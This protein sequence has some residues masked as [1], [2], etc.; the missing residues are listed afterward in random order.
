MCL[1]YENKSKSKTVDE[2]QLVGSSFISISYYLYSIRIYSL[3]KKVV[4]SPLK[5]HPYKF[6]QLQ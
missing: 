1:F 3:L 4:I 2:H 6:I 5:A